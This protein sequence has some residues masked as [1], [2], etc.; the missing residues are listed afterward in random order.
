MATFSS[1][2]PVGLGD[3]IYIKSQLDFF[4]DRF[5]EIHITFHEDLI[6]YYRKGTK[7]NI[8]LKEVG[9]LF[10]SEKPYILNDGYYPFRTQ[11]QICTDYEMPPCKPEL[12]HLLCKGVSL[13]LDSEYIVLTTKIRQLSRTNFNDMSKDFWD[14][15]NQ[16]SKKYKIVLLG[17]RKVEVNKEYEYYTTEHIYSI[18]EDIMKNVQ[19]EAI[20]DLTIPALGIT[21]PSLTQIQQDCLIMKEAKFVVTIGI[22]GNFCMATAVA[23]VIGYRNDDDEVADYCF[24]N[25]EYPN[26]MITKNYE[27][28][29]S[30]LGKYI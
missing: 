27:Y 11:L 1:N 23:N 15:I 22:G 30:I 25:R 3:I 8:F 28:F 16:L 6:S 21:V 26:A 10:F 7:Y 9:N 19:N 13:N 2:I 4:K 29:M 14:K 20:I 12:Q 17:E 5:E 18:Y 24:S